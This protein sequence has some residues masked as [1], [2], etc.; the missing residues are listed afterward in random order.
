[1]DVVALKNICIRFISTRF[2]HDV[3]CSIINSRKFQSQ[4]YSVYILE[5][6]EFYHLKELM[7]ELAMTTLCYIVGHF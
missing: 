2:N 1:M 5:E 4:I 6:K 3:L 7:N